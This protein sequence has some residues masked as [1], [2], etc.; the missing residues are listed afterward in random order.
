MKS[1][2]K[3]KTETKHTFLTHIMLLLSSFTY[4]IMIKFLKELSALGFDNSS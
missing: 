3:I 2:L 4:L 1:H